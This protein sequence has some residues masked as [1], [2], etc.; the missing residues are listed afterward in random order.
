MLESSRYKP[1]TTNNVATAVHWPELQEKHTIF[2]FAIVCGLFVFN[3]F[4]VVLLLSLHAIPLLSYNSPKTRIELNTNG[5]LLFD[6]FHSFQYNNWQQYLTDKEIALNALTKHTP[7]PVPL[8]GGYKAEPYKQPP[9]IGSRSGLPSSL[10][11]NTTGLLM[12]P[13]WGSYFK[14]ATLRSNDPARVYIFGDSQMA[15]GDLYQSLKRRLQTVYGNGGHGWIR[16]KRDCTVDRG[17]FRSVYGLGAPSGSSY[18]MDQNAVI[19]CNNIDATK[20]KLWYYT[21]GGVN[22]PMGFTIR[23]NGITISTASMIN[24]SSTEQINAFVFDAPNVNTRIQSLTFTG[25]NSIGMYGIEAWHATTGVVVFNWALPKPGCEYSCSGND[26]LW[27]LP[28]QQWLGINGVAGRTTS[29]YSIPDLIITWFSGLY[30]TGTTV[31]VNDYTSLVNSILTDVGRSNGAY[32]ILFGWPVTDG[33]YTSLYY[34]KA[35]RNYALNTIGSRMAVLDVSAWLGVSYHVL[36]NL[37][38]YL[39]CSSTNLPSVSNWCWNQPT[40]I[41][42]SDIGVNLTVPY[43]EILLNGTG[44]FVNSGI[45]PYRD[46][47]DA[48]PIPIPA[49]YLNR[50]APPTNVMKKGYG[51]QPESA[52]PFLYNCHMLNNVNSSWYY[53]WQITEA[54]YDTDQ[55]DKMDYM[56]LVFSEWDIQFKSALQLDRLPPLEKSVFLAAWNEPNIWWESGVTPQRTAEL[57][58]LFEQTGRLLITPS[59]AQSGYDPASPW[60]RHDWFDKWIESCLTILGRPCQYDYSS[61]HLYTCSLWDL[62]NQVSDLYYQLG[63]PVW[64]TEYGCWGS[65]PYGDGREPYPYPSTSQFFI[66]ASS[67]MDSSPMVYRYAWYTFRTFENDDNGGPAGWRPESIYTTIDDHEKAMYYSG[68]GDVSQLIRPLDSLQITPVGQTFKNYV[69]VY[70]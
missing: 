31:N 60:K 5:T 56:P 68:I 22:G 53:N 11:V 30:E 4:L 29:S 25:L 15:Q 48:W 50:P 34:K 1:I 46:P 40:G 6:V 58:P 38:G 24:S 18:N 37:G 65:V 47:S 35:I 36:N 42:L 62:Q 49:A 23:V 13:G 2:F 16:P 39:P 12:S 33:L 70:P 57:W 55:I 64:V 26:I 52:H 69:S 41:Y 10:F 8:L 27:M 66:D 51:L 9:P 21:N 54:C 14:A 63:K 61:L 45:W 3:V 19:T 67:W 7:S 32:D 20:F 43:I 17:E 44:M 59:P 28:M